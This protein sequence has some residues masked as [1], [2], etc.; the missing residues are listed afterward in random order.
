MAPTLVTLKNGVLEPAYGVYW[1][2]NNKKEF[3]SVQ[4]ASKYPLK[5]KMVPKV[6]Q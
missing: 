5:F 1:W 2:L 4:K 3:D 6:T